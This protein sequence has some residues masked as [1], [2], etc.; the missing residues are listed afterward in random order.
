MP[1]SGSSY[2]SSQFW[3]PW[4]CS[5]M[6][7]SICLCKW[8]RRYNKKGK[9]NLIDSNQVV[10]KEIPCRLVL[11][12][13]NSILN[14]D[15][16]LPVNWPHYLY[17]QTHCK[18]QLDVQS[19]GHWQVWRWQQVAFICRLIYHLSLRFIPSKIENLDPIFIKGVSIGQ[20][21][22][23]PYQFLLFV[24]LSIVLVMTSIHIHFLCPTRNI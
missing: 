23:W 3:W 9:Q 20:D 5:H 19:D 15:G 14:T 8:S 21:I 18:Y 17:K 10:S 13:L 24:Q 11:A 2:F 1:N 12:T 22:K 16:R 4:A 7:T 6:S